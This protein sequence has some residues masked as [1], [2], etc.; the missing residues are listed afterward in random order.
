MLSQLSY[1]SLLCWILPTPD[2]TLFYY[3][4]TDMLSLSL[5]LSLLLAIYSF[6][7]LYCE[8]NKFIIWSW[9]HGYQITVQK[10]QSRLMADEWRDEHQMSPCHMYPRFNMPY[11]LGL[12]SSIHKMSFRYADKSRHQTSLFLTWLKHKLVVFVYFVLLF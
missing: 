1:S 11:D 5:P 2:L 10:K 8:F 7:F 4:F 3:L 6:T 12:L 9:K